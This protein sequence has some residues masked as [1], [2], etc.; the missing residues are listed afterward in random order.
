MKGLPSDVNRAASCNIPASGHSPF[1]TVQRKIDTF[2][3]LFQPFYLY[4]FSAPYLSTAY[5]GGPAMKH[6]NEYGIILVFA[7]L[8]AAVSLVARF[9]GFHEVLVL[10][11][12]TMMM[13]IILSLRKEMNITF[14]IL[15]VILINF[16]GKWI[17]E[18]I[19]YFVRAY[20]FPPVPIRHYIAGP[21]CNFVTTWILGLLQLGGIALVRRS[22][23][24]KKTDTHNA[25]WLIVAF[26]TV[27]IIRMAMII[28]SSGNSYQENVVLNLVID[29]GCSIAAILLMA[30]YVLSERETA[31]TEK[32]KRHEAQYSYE[33]LKQQIEPHFLFNSLNS[34]GNI[35]ETD[36]KDQ[37][38]SFIRKLCSIYRYLIDK[39]EKPAVPLAEELHFVNMYV[40]LMKV[41]YPEGLQWEENISEETAS[42]SKIIPCSLQLLV[43]NA[44]KH[45]SFSSKD[46]LQISVRTADGYIEVSNNR[47]PKQTSQPSTGNGQQ[48][49]R[50]RYHDE[51]GKDIVIQETSG[52]YTVKLPLM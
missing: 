28:E 35:I 34:L 6:I 37:A 9:V 30:R 14:M 8:H 51:I 32:R 4:L 17:G 52:F 23:F 49:I 29:Y 48:Y 25:I 1:L 12:L 41:R 13:S 31:R 40:D 19:G 15:A 11:L 2:Y 36:G 5:C 18:Q 3:S 33:R 10:T 47:R 22:R 7:L 38:M 16:I 21:V 43:E 45:N 27:L 26:A 46:P 39:E 44:I 24:F 50:K 20:V 42:R